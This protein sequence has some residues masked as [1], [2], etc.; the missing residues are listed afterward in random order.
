MHTSSFVIDKAR[1]LTASGQDAEVQEMPY[2]AVDVLRLAW[3]EEDFPGSP[4]PLGFLRQS[5]EVARRRGN[6]EWPV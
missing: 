5:R 1:Q 3:H 6:S 4:M 2:E